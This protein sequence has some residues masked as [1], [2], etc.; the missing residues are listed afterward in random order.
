LIDA[1]AAQ[2]EQVYPDGTRRIGH[3]PHCAPEAYLHRLFA[4]LDEPSIEELQNQLDWDFP[5][6]FRRFLSLH[7]GVGVFSMFINVYGMRTS[8]TRTDP[9]VAAQQPFSILNPN[10]DR[11]PAEA[12]DDLLFIGSL[13]DQRDLIGMLPDGEVSLWMPKAGV[14]PPKQYEDVFDF[15]LTETKKARVLFDNRGRRKDGS[16][17]L[18]KPS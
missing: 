4:P 18:W 15:L 1:W 12:P 8:W 3:I 2:G 7:N 6:S 10:V 11:R 13:G 17:V 16:D 9:V 14:V 5:E